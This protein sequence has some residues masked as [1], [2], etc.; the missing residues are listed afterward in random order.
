MAQQTF[1]RDGD[2]RSV[3][4]TEQQSVE[5]TGLKR[6]APTTPTFTQKS[7]LSSPTAPS[8]VKQSDRVVPIPPK[9]A[10]CEHGAE[11]N[12][13]RKL[14]DSVESATL[15]QSPEPGKKEQ[16]SESLLSASIERLVGEV[17][18]RAAS[19]DNEIS[20]LRRTLQQVYEE[21]DALLEQ[22]ETRTVD[23]HV[24]KSG[25]LELEKTG[26]EASSTNMKQQLFLA[27]AAEKTLSS[28]I[29]TLRK[30]RE[31]LLNEN[32][33]LQSES[34]CRETLNQDC[35]RQLGDLRAEHSRA[36]KERDQT[37]AQNSQELSTKMAE[38]ASKDKLIFEKDREL[39]SWRRYTAAAGQAQSTTL[40]EIA[41]LRDERAA[42]IAQLRDERTKLAAQLVNKS[43]TII[44]KDSELGCLRSSKKEADQAQ[45]TS[46]AQNA[47][48][49]DECSKLT[50]QLKEEGQQVKRL[51]AK[52]SQAVQEYQAKEQANETEKGKLS[53]QIKKLQCEKSALVQHLT[54]TET[55]HL[56]S[57]NARAEE[58]HEETA[59]WAS[60]LNDNKLKITHIKSRNT[61]AKWRILT[62]IA[63]RDCV[64]KDL[65]ALQVKHEAAE[66]KIRQLQI[67]LTESTQGCSHAQTEL[68]EAK[69]KA[70][71]MANQLNVLKTELDGLKIAKSAADRALVAARKQTSE[72]DKKLN[73]LKTLVKKEP[74]RSAESRVGKE[75]KALEKRLDEKCVENKWLDTRY[76]EVLDQ[77]QALDKEKSELLASL[78]RYDKVM[79]ERG[80]DTPSDL[81]ASNPPVQVPPSNSTRPESEDRGRRTPHSIPPRL[82]V[83]AN[84]SHPSAAA[85]GLRSAPCESRGMPPPQPRAF[86]YESDY[87]RRYEQ[88]A[89][90]ERGSPGFEQYDCETSRRYSSRDDDRRRDSREHRWQDRDRTYAERANVDRGDRYGRR[91]DSDHWRPW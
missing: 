79:V 14:D 74:P 32:R 50:A 16:I 29:D 15:L 90:H 52:V 30:E 34:D 56:R 44:E 86:H 83:Q 2:G 42:E 67:Q 40:A 36:L 65:E 31:T 60:R 41:Q 12:K 13:K 23:L 22:H 49:R 75:R 1:S 61:A 10:Q 62:A 72:K 38:L 18:A 37:L 55:R 85:V 48:L 73:S 39:E 68:A 25:N 21:R 69:G 8:T 57:M 33:V 81:K 87:Q 28:Q 7:P 20:K 70:E 11:P 9:S 3:P 84:R 89:E 59:R 46:L 5:D 19:K 82:S 4:R 43:K 66:H 17:L 53:E 88:P 77:K 78:Q 26:L 54:D 64:R 27:Q 35:V 58:F 47:Q 51:E 24:Y 63:K 45:A 71:Y 6:A 76:Q 91:R 80:T